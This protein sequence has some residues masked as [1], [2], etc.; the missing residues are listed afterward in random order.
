VALPP[1]SS[2]LAEEIEFHSRAA[3]RL[4]APPILAL[5][6]LAS[7]D[8]PI[9]A[10]TWTW[11]IAWV[12]GLS[13]TPW[14]LFLI[15]CGTWT[16]YASDRIL[17][18][19]RATRSGDLAVLHERHFFHWRHRNKFIPIAVLTGIS[20]A[21]A[22]LCLM[23]LRSRAQNVV[24]AAAAFVYITC[25][26]FQVRL[27]SSVS[28]IVSKEFIVGVLFTA[29]CAAPVLSKMRWIHPLDLWPVLACV[30]FFAILAWLNCTA[31]QRWESGRDGFRIQTSAS[32]ICATGL[33]LALA[34]YFI[35]ARVSSL[36]S[37]GAASAMLLLLLDRSRH[38]L[39]PLLLRALADVVLLTPAVLLIFKELL[40]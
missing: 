13:V 8:A 37:L 22:V 19:H 34:V 20:T 15:A 23:P 27:P 6:H 38:H 33:V 10:V 2:S 21:V 9:V 39:T 28:R 31:I 30:S 7:L 3:V 17:D 1:A 14:F 18:A 12:T 32:L 36:V 16:I 40:K 25:V 26:H 24:I 5:W 4:K 35:Q 11:A 29:G